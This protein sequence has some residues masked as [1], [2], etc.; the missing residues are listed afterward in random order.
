MKKLITIVVLLLSLL[1]VF[2]ACDGLLN[3]ATTVDFAKINQMVTE[4]HSKVQIDVSV[5]KTDATDV[6]LNSAFTCTYNDD[7]SILVQYRLEQ[8]NLIDVNNMPTE[9]KSVKQG[10]VT[11]KDGVVSNQTGEVVDVD[12]SAIA[13][14]KITFSDSNL[15]NGK[16]QNGI[17][18]ADVISISA[19]MG[20]NVV[21]ATNIKVSVNINAL[22]SCQV[23]YQVNGSQV[24]LDYTFIK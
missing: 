12:F 16:V 24:T 7:S 18:T 17:Y 10:S 6:C 23:S 14:P 11:V 9:A 21:G 20:S 3:P 8:F 19:L 4:K 22:N 1:V 2:S 15:A 5:V 13:Q